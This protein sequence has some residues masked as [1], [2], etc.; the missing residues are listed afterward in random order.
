MP[1]AIRTAS[2]LADYLGHDIGA[3][4]PQELVNLRGLYGAIKD[5]EAT[6]ASA[7]ENKAENQPPAG[8][9]NGQGA[10]GGQQQAYPQDQ[11]QK[12]LPGWLK[13][14]ADKKK[15]ADQ[16]IATVQTKHQLTDAQKAQ[17]RGEQPTAQPDAKSDGSAVVVTFKQVADAIA[18]AVKDKSADALA[19]AGDLIGEVQD[20]AHRKELQ[21]LYEAGEAEIAK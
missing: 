5:G 2:Q 10:S 16:I 17:I 4:S 13:A 6:W 19:T 8:A 7:M 3:C 11:F 1:R 14:I 12:N 21:G 9:G 15:T 20:P 18:A